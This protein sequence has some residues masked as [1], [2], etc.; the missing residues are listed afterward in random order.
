MSTEINITIGDQRLLQES[1]TRAAANQQSLDSRLEEQQLAEQLTE[2]VDEATPEDPRSDAFSLQLDRRPAAQRRRKE[3]DKFQIARLGNLFPRPVPNSAQSFFPGT[4]FFTTTLFLTKS[5]LSCPAEPPPSP[6]TNPYTLD[7]WIQIFTERPLNVNG[8]SNFYSDISVRFAPSLSYLGSSYF[9]PERTLDKVNR[10]FFR[11]ISRVTRLCVTFFTQCS[12]PFFIKTF[13]GDVVSNGPIFPRQSIN[14]N[15]ST[16][17]QLI[18]STSTYLYFS[19]LLRH[20]EYDV[21]EVERVDR[22]EIIRVKDFTS[23]A[24]GYYVRFNTKD[25]TVESRIVTLSSEFLTGSSFRETADPPSS[26]VSLA[27][28]EAFASNFYPDDPRSSLRAVDLAQSLDFDI[29]H[30]SYNPNTGAA[31]FY[32]QHTV[33]FI[34]GSPNQ[35]SPDA[36]VYFTRFDKGTPYG[37]VVGVLKKAKLLLRS[38]TTAP[39]VLTDNSFNQTF[40]RK[41]FIALGGVKV[42][43]PFPSEILAIVPQV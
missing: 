34:D 31:Y 43:S 20:R 33:V 36:F 22:A 9:L 29:N 24:Q 25:F 13:E 2:A 4:W 23:I 7:N 21:V 38:L 32:G 17:L 19:T 6:N 16:T 3:D 27:V 35:L 11:W 14:S 1:K 42:E 12:F 18:S 41:Q 28:Q 8:E 5:T 39:A 37:E 10:T 30:F 40:T 26:F 15:L